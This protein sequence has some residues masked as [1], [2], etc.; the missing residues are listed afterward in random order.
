MAG[1]TH[2][3]SG[4]TVWHVVSIIGAVVAIVVSIV[5]AIFGSVHYATQ[6]NATLLSTYQTEAL[7]LRRENNATFQRIDMRL[8]NID[9]RLYRIEST[10][11]PDDAKQPALFRHIEK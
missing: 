11:V 9:K 6:A 8:D 4:I 7:E 1:G 5:G 3:G 10:I 2:N